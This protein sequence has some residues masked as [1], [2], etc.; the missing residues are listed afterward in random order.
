MA[1]TKSRSKLA[2]KTTRGETITFGCIPVGVVEDEISR[3]DSDGEYKR[4]L[5]RIRLTEAKT[6]EIGSA[7]AY[8]WCYFSLSESRD[9]LPIGHCGLLVGEHELQ[10]ILAEARLKRWPI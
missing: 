4:F 5:Q 1:P 3:I 6:G 7:Y 2:D 10:N 8:R 9:K